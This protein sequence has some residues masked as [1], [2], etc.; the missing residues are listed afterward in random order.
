MRLA[1]ACGTAAIALLAPMGAFAQESGEATLLEEIR[2]EQGSGKGGEARKTGVERVKGVVTKSTRS[3]SKSATPLTEI[4]QSV[5]VVGRE[6]M[7]MQSPQ[8]VDEAL[9]YAPGVNPST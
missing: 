1:L 8:K 5:T 2:V 3:G 4:P 9:R 7:E 6:Q